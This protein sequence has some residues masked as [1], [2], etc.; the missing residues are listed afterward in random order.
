MKYGSVVCRVCAC[1]LPFTALF[2]LGTWQVFRRQEKLQIIERMNS[3]SV[4]MPSNMKANAYKT[5]V[6]V[7]TFKEEYFRVFAGRRGYYYLQLFALYD[8]RHI[9][10]NRGTFLKNAQPVISSGETKERIEGV[11]HCKLSSKV[12]WVVN[13]NAEE[14]VWVWFDVKNMAKHI[15]VPLESCIV[16]GNN[17]TAG[18]GLQP[19]VMPKIRNDHTEYAVTWYTLAAVWLFGFMSFLKK[20]KQVT[21]ASST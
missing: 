20:K 18:E 3:S 17:T 10:V 21:N 12:R 19:N 15:S 8:S 16:W 9:L 7:G 11:L 14:N 13:N 2:S 1:M 5:V 6:I 4:Y